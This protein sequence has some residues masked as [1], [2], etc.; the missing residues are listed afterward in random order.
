M[1]EEDKEEQDKIIIWMYVYTLKNVLNSEKSFQ[2][3]I[4]YLCYI[5]LFILSAF[6]MC[7]LLSTFFT[8]LC[9]IFKLTIFVKEPS[10]LMHVLQKK[11]EISYLTIFM[12]H[13]F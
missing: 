6:F 12:I 2:S 5:H 3:Q 9:L 10:L 11:G 7:V 1:D 8:L 13:R 4:D